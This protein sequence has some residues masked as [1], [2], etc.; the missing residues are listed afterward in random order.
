MVALLAGI[1]LLGE[2]ALCEEEGSEG[3]PHLKYL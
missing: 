2:G 1:G 3:I